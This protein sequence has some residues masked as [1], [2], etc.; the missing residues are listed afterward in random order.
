MNRLL[1]TLSLLVVAL[2]AAPAPAV[3]KVLTPLSK[4]VTPVP[5]IFV[6]E[7]DK[8]DPDKPSVIFKFSENLKGKTTLERL[9]VNLTGDSFSKK[10]GHTK[11][12][13]DRLAPGR[14]LILFVVEEKGKLYATG[15]I[16]GTWFQ[17]DGTVDQDTKAVRWAFLHAEPYFRRTF[18][19]TTA[20]L[21]AVIEGAVAGTKKPPE[22]DESVPHGF[23]PTVEEEKKKEKQE[24]KDEPQAN[25]RQQP[26]GFVSGPLFGV[27]PT[28]VFI[29]PLAILAAIFP[30][31]FAGFA[32]GLQRWRA[33]LVVMSI[34]GTLAAVYYFTRTS[35]PDAWYASE[36]A[37]A[38]LILLV[39]I[40]GLGIAGRRYRIVAQEDPRTTEAPTR[41]ELLAVAGFAIATPVILGTMFWWF[42][43]PLS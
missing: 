9:P 2:S 27:I 21:K 8:V 4:V 37:Y 20:E 24:K 32:S 15:F 11:V 16:E 43:L 5:F 38:S 30:N 14:K 3:I 13:L 25:G 34:N 10:D 28:V 41:P 7:V 40:A 19:G 26:A 12:M 23:G 33:F 35:L 29:G 36:T 18:K 22:P 1:A 42:E 39:E 31:V 17:M 6:A